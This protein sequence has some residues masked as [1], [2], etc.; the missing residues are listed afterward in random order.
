MKQQIVYDF[1]LRKDLKIR[2]AFLRHI[3]EQGTVARPLPYAYLLKIDTIN[4]KKE[5]KKL[6]TASVRLGSTSSVPVFPS[7]IA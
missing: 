3:K 7:S 6:T 4:L 1:S 2:I 5:T